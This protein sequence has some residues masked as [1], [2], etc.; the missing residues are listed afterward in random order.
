LVKL[1]LSKTN[2]SYF[3]L[4]NCESDPGLGNGGLGPA[5]LIL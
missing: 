5:F 1:V 4:V 3:D 2:R